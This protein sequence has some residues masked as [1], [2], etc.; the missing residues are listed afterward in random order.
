MAG[1]IQ[2][3]IKTLHRPGMGQ[4]R[5]LFHTRFSKVSL[6]DQST[7]FVASKMREHS[8]AA[9]LTQAVHSGLQQLTTAGVSLLLQIDRRVAAHPHTSSMSFYAYKYT[10]NGYFAFY[11]P[12]NIG[13]GA[14]DS[15]FLE[16]HD[17]AWLCL[18]H[19]RGKCQPSMW[20]RIIWRS[21]EERT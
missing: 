21:V 13:E 2:N 18:C 7:F 11:S 14:A 3:I 8:W 10:I 20:M 16:R 4:P 17:R 15:T 19:R 9:G 1:S 12:V 6:H 5:G